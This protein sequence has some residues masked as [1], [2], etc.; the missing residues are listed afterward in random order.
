MKLF[1]KNCTEMPFSNFVNSHQILIRCKINFTLT[2]WRRVTHNSVAEDLS[3]LCIFIWF[4]SAKFVKTK[5]MW[6][7]LR[8]KH[9]KPVIRVCFP[10]SCCPSGHQGRTW[11]RWVKPSSSPLQNHTCLHFVWPAEILVT[12]ISDEYQLVNWLSSKYSWNNYTNN[13]LLVNNIR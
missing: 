3:L 10:I 13:S 8:K 4:W 5:Y 2:L 7:K 1:F 11:G 12:T 9:Y 6:S